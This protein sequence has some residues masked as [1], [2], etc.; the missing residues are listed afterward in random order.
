MSAEKND[1]VTEDRQCTYNMAMWRV[2]VT[3]FAVE[4]KEFFFPFVFLLTYMY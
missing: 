1:S 3:I 4:R 2:R